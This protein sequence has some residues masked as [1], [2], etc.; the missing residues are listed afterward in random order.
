MP[1]LSLLTT[2]AEQTR[3][4][5]ADVAD[6]LEP[7]DVLVLTGELGAGKTTF[8]QGVAAGLGVEDAVVSPTFV[9]VREYRG[10]LPL[11]HADV[12]RLDRVQDAI[13]LGLD[14]AADGGVLMVEW[15]D[16]VEDLLG[17]DRL[18]IELRLAD[19]SAPAAGDARRIDVT[20]IGPSWD[21]RAGRLAATL[22]PWAEGAGS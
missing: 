21:V 1:V 16:A 17:A 9:L 6:L 12:Y 22:E 2:G 8:T 14:E 3:S 5:G 13:D 10:R 15:G 7:G 4:L 11:V 20:A 19:A 18:R